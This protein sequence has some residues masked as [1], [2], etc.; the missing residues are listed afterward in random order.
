MM[1]LLLYYSQLRKLPTV[2]IYVFISCSL[3]CSNLMYAPL[4]P[5][6]PDRELSQST[7]SEITQGNK[8]AESMSNKHSVDLWNEIKKIKG[9]HKA[10]HK[11]RKK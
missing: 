1:F 2:L 10:M 11:Q 5:S 4:P 8:I 6:P 9:T 3:S 7:R